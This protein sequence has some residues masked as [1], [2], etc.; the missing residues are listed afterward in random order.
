[1][2]VTVSV[3]LPITEHHVG[4]CEIPKISS[5]LPRRSHSTTRTKWRHLLPGNRGLAVE[6][7]RIPGEAGGPARPNGEHGPFGL[8]IVLHD[9]HGP[10]RAEVVAL[11]VIAREQVVLFL[12]EF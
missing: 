6:P 12:R 8:R 4:D 1:M 5:M 9:P 7:A 11:D 2:P 3:N 10:P